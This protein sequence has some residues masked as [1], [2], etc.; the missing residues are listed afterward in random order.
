MSYSKEFE[1]LEEERG[2]VEA[3]A[4]A[5]LIPISFEI[6]KKT[7]AE[8]ANL[9]QA[10]RTWKTGMKKFYGNNWRKFNNVPL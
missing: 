7:P 2:K 8:K 4:N 1:L 5:N 3:E 9:S 10:Q 6:Y